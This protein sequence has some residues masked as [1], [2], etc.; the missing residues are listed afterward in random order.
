[1]PDPKFDGAWGWVLA[2]GCEVLLRARECRGVKRR[3]PG[4]CKWCCD[5]LSWARL[6]ACIACA[7]DANW[8]PAVSL[9]MCSSDKGAFAGQEDSVQS[10]TGFR[11]VVINLCFVS[12][13]AKALVRPLGC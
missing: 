10:A 8:L 7:D 4:R 12:P 5:W 6:S 1:M 2:L 3:G 13:A 11:A 9:H